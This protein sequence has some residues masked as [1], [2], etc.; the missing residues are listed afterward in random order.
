[1]RYLQNN[2][3]VFFIQISMFI[4]VQFTVRR[5]CCNKPLPEAMINII[6]DTIWRQ[7]SYKSNVIKAGMTYDRI[8]YTCI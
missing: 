6:S 8:G 2:I 3:Y 4:G 7:Q 1:M 5:R